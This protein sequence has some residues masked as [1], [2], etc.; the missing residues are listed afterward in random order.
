LARRW[1][2]AIIDRAHLWANSDDCG[3]LRACG[4]NKPN[5]ERRLFQ[6]WA[7]SDEQQQKTG[8]AILS[9]CR[10]CL[11]DFRMLDTDF[12]AWLEVRVIGR[13]G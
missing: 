10:E 2:F 7:S 4:S 1:C 3:D 8:S 5:L 13:E 11:D 12:I 9:L 6:H